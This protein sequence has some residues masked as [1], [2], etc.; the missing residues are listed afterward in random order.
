M[1]I[2]QVRINTLE[3]L[4]VEGRAEEVSGAD[5]M[6][7]I[8]EIDCHVHYSTALAFEGYRQSELNGFLDGVRSEWDAQ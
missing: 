8:E 7:W 4:I 1:D 6:R 5:D 3:T 2:G